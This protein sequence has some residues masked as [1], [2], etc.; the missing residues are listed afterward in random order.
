MQQS[1]KCE[2]DNE[3]EEKLLYTSA[4]MRVACEYAKA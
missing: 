1:M 3:L 4:I 2:V